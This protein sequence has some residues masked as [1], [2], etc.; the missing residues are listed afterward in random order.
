MAGRT[1]SGT[2]RIA[3]AHQVRE[4]LNIIDPPPAD[5]ETYRHRIECALD[6]IGGAERAV[7]HA[8]LTNKTRR[9]YSDALR[10]MRHA[11][12]RQLQAGGP[13]ALSPARIERAV[14]SD[15]AWNK[16]W[17]PPS[18]WL[19]HE[20]A[21]ALAYDLISHKPEA[22]AVSRNGP[23]HQLAAVLFGDKDINLFRHLR[24]FSQIRPQ[25]E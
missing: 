25:Q 13:V 1:R 10:R 4:A 23:W 2:S 8:K 17:S 9:S 18:R 15:E 24:K 22:I 5:R 20:F 3:R 14:K 7:E 21:V 19:K 12:R 16:G 6:R 11:T